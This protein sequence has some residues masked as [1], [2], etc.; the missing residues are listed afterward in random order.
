MHKFRTA[1]PTRAAAAALLALSCAGLTVPATAAAAPAVTFGSAHYAHPLHGF[2]GDSNWG[3]YIATGSRFTSVT[4]SWT[5]PHVTCNSSND[6]YAPWIGIDGYG[7]QTVEQ[8]G[9]QVDCS[10]GSP[11]YSGWYEMYP[12]APRY[13][14]NPVSAGDAFTA[15]VTDT[16][17]GS[18]TLKLTDTTKGWTKTAT[19]RLSAR[20]ASAEAV[21]ESPTG[22]YPSF[23]RQDFSGITVNGR[24]FATYGPQ[25]IDSGPYTETALNGGSFS[26]IP[27]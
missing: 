27:G 22:S 5:M 17:G 4:G 24:S 25:A 16:G 9:V 11:Q 15:S 26:I 10:S 7:S 23:S 6:L 12:A 20:D 3:G 14:S 19:S 2:S 1:V 18:Y 8:T 13:F 21:I